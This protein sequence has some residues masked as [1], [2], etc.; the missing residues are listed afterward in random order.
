MTS[1]CQVCGAAMRLRVTPTL[2]GVAETW[3]CM[4]WAVHPRLFFDVSKKRTEGAPIGGVL[5]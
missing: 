3:E 2:T 4:R 5:R 1:T